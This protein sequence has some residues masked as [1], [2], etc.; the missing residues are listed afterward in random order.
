MP[1]NVSSSD[2]GVGLDS[3]G[4][5]ATSRLTTALT[6]VVVKRAAIKADVAD[7]VVEVLIRTAAASTAVGSSDT[8]R[9]TENQSKGYAVADS[10][11]VV[12]TASAVIFL[13]LSDG[14]TGTGSESAFPTWT[15]SDSDAGTATSVESINAAVATVENGSLNDGPSVQGNVSASDV[16]T[17]TEATTILAGLTAVTD[18]GSSAEVGTV[19]NFLA[20]SSADSGSTTE[21]VGTLRITAAEISTAVDT[22]ALAS[23]VGDFDFGTEH[24]GYDIA[25]ASADSTT[26]TDSQV[27]VMIADVS[28]GISRVQ[29]TSSNSYLQLTRDVAATL[30]R[31][32]D[33]AAT[34][35]AVAIKDVQAQ[36]H[37]TQ[38]ASSTGALVTT[39][40]SGVGVSRSQTMSVT[41]DGSDVVMPEQPTLQFDFFNSLLP[42]VSGGQVIV[43][44]ALGEPDD[45][46]SFYWDNATQPI[47]TAQLD[48]AGNLIGVSVLVPIGISAGSH[49][50][51]VLG[52]DFGMAQLIVPVTSDVPAPVTETS[53]APLPPPPPTGQRWH[54]FDPYTN[55]TYLLPIGPHD[56]DAPYLARN[57]VAAGTT[58]PMGQ[59]VVWEGGRRASEWTASGKLLDGAQVD[60]MR[61]WRGRPHRVWLY[62][63][64]GRAWL[65]KITGV[66]LTPFRDLAHPMAHDWVL[67]A[68]IYGRKT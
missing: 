66:E 46:V 43:N 19:T 62:D 35:I 8:G 9:G 11:S 50:L 29:S 21:A 23:Q 37:R 33:I 36:P 16:G 52:Q 48:D 53:S 67:H 39:A 28:V 51:T 58:S 24:C 56:I 63:P 27:R 60:A 42:V 20:V 22:Q 54:L 31:T 38:Q 30:P 5:T 12:E 32:R 59:K 65:I 25:V 49:T 41:V 6:E 40:E 68:L 17:G 34:T 13:S 1:T 45:S 4:G 61:A 14:D 7:A 64:L 44:V 18:S 26:A 10:G 3:I 57:I 55:E 2:S 47:Q 15:F